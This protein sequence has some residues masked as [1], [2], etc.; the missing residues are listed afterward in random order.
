MC[1]LPELGVPNGS[2]GMEWIKPVMLSDCTDDSGY[3]WEPG[4]ESRTPSNTC[5]YV[6][7]TRYC[8]F[9]ATQLVGQGF[10]EVR[11]RGCIIDSRHSTNDS[12]AQYFN[13][14][15]GYSFIIIVMYRFQLL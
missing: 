3:S 10:S 5:T 4:A 15:P 13:S 12:D 7:W 1:K 6:S 14:R 11:P 9:I 8:G 2:E